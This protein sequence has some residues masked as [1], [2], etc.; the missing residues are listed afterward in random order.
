MLKF[1]TLSSSLYYTPRLLNVSC[2][3][4]TRFI[5]SLSIFT[6]LIDTATEKGLQHS[7]VWVVRVESR[8]LTPFG[9]CIC[10]CCF[11]MQF[12]YA[13]R[14]AAGAEILGRT[15]GPVS[16]ASTTLIFHITPENPCYRIIILTDVGKHMISSGSL[17]V[18]V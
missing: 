3:L 11:S 12:C 9:N 2:S 7:M 8:D 15:P 14:W 13:E 16:C 5:R 18:S 4:L 10:S 6:P 1:Y 17:I